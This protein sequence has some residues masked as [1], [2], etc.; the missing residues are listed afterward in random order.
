MLLNLRLIRPTPV[1]GISTNNYLVVWLLFVV[2]AL[3]SDRVLERR[4]WDGA[5]QAGALASFGIH[6]VQTQRRGSLSHC[7]NL[8]FL[9]LDDQYHRSVAARKKTVELEFFLILHSC[10]FWQTNFNKE[11]HA[12]HVTTVY[13]NTNMADGSCDRDDFAQQETSLSSNQAVFPDEEIKQEVKQEVS[14]PI[15]GFPPLF[16]FAKVQTEASSWTSTS[17]TTTTATGC[18]SYAT[19]DTETNEQ[20]TSSETVNA[21]ESSSMDGLGLSSISEASDVAAKM[22]EESSLGDDK[23]NEEGDKDDGKDGEEVANDEPDEEEIESDPYFYIKR[24]EF[25]SEIYKIELQ[26]LPRKCG[27]KVSHCMY[28]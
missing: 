7:I 15:P 2:C 23:V 20:P 3:E 12:F 24:D 6:E 16:Q 1:P 21:V 27:Y 10:E 26:N 14:T 17:S 28:T 19:L 4:T 11:K 18:G 5:S 22:Q 8:C 25:T 13:F 9:F